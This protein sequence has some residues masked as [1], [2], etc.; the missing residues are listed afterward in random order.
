MRSVEL[1]LD[2]GA[3]LD[4]R[5]SDGSTPVMAAA[6]VDGFDAVYVLLT[7]GADYCAVSEHGSDLIDRMN[8]RQPL[9][10]SRQAYWRKK[11]AA[12]L[13]ERG[14]DVRSGRRDFPLSRGGRPGCDAA[15]GA[16]AR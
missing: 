13:E 1:L 8:L 6:S 5:A 3:D 9:P 15:Q 2:A 10:D 7:R 16:R 14:V 12:W 11:V 4:A